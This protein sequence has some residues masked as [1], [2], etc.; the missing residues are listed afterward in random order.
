[1]AWVFSFPV[2]L[3]SSKSRIKAE[4]LVLLQLVCAAPQEL[5]VAVGAAV[6]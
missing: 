5:A 4:K 3:N 1:M 6:Q 2:V